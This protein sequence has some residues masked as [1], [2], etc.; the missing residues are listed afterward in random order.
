MIGM[1][2]V[3]FIIMFGCLII[4]DWFVD[5]EELEIC[6][7]KFIEVKFI[8]KLVWDCD[9]GDG[10][11]YYFF[12]FCFVYVYDK[13]YV[14]DCYGVVVVMDFE[15][16]KVLWE[17][18]FVQ[19]CFEGM[20]S[21]VINLW[22]SGEIVCIGGI[23]VVDRYVFIGIENGYV[24]VMDVEIGELVWDVF[25]F[26]EILV[27]LVVDEGILVV[28]MGVGS[29][30]GFNICIGEQLWRYEGDIFLLILCGIFG[31]IVFNGG[32]IIGIF[33][34]KIQVNFI[35]I[36][37]FVW[38][39]VIVMFFGVIELECIVDIDII[40]VLFGGMVYMVFY[41]GILVV[42]ELCLGCVIWKCEYVLFCNL[43]I[44]GNKIFVV[45]NNFNVYVFDR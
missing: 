32:V 10:V 12:C 34:G 1:V 20:L 18:D 25:V 19:F 3:V 8:F 36:G 26:G 42:V 40:F 38:E 27:V 24:V 45:D 5:D 23:V 11:N 13:F 31:L 30:F 28:N 4:L 21:L 6:C 39:M 17:K 37:V 43:N 33:I 2:F 41:N 35:E 29:L 14:V 22:C 9:I 44:D 15:L 7:L 16:G